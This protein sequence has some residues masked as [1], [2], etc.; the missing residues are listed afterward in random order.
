M[1]PEWSRSG[2]FLSLAFITKTYFKY[3]YLHLKMTLERS[4][5]R[6]FLSVVFISHPVLILPIIT[7]LGNYNNVLFET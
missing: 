5:S 1:T 7:L 2:D 3:F 6:D 4:K